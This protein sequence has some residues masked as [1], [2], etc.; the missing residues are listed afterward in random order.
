M[1]IDNIACIKMFDD[2]KFRLLTKKIHFNKTI[3]KEWLI[4]FEY[5]QRPDDITLLIF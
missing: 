1:A 3:F 4:S 5:Y 2:I